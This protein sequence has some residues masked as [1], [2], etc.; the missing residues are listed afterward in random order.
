MDV[1]PWGPDGALLC[2]CKATIFKLNFQC[3]CDSE[4]FEY[5]ISHTPY[6]ISELFMRVFD[7]CDAI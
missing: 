6:Q 2:N 5:G 7:P 3:Y 1:R 4:T